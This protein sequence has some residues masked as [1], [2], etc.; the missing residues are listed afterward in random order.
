MCDFCGRKFAPM[1]WNQRTCVSC[2]TEGA[3][4]QSVLPWAVYQKRLADYLR[5][6]GR[7]AKLS[8]AAASQRQKA[9]GLGELGRSGQT[10]PVSVVRDAEPV[11][12]R[13]GAAGS[14][15]A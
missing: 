10:A 15:I 13:V 11:S 1:A 7:R 4:D 9:R 2:A 12:G 3:P 14:E 5:E 8:G 6:Q